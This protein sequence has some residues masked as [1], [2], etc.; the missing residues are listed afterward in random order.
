MFETQ[1]GANVDGSMLMYLRPE[2]AQ[3]IVVNFRNVLGAGDL[4]IDDIGLKLPKP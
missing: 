4:Y 3:G 2:T 1:M